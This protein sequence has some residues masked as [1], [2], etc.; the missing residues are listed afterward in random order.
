MLSAQHCT[1]D[2][3]YV[4]D[5]IAGFLAIPHCIYLHL[6]FSNTVV[7]NHIRDCCIFAALVSDL[8]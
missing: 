4:L 5:I 1:V 3:H 6:V 2:R 8:W 7:R